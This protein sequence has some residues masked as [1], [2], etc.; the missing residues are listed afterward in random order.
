MPRNTG[1]SMGKRNASAGK[2]TPSSKKKAAAKRK[3]PHSDDEDESFA[4]HN[5]IRIQQELDAVKQENEALKSGETTAP[6]KHNVRYG[7]ESNHIPTDFENEV[8]KY[9]EEE[10]WANTKF[11]AN[12]EENMGVCATI[13]EGMPEFAGLLTGNDAKNKPTIK[14]FMDTYGKIVTKTLNS[15]RTNCQGNLRK[16]YL[17]R[18]MAG[19]Y[20]PT[21]KELLEAVM[22]PVS[23]MDDLKALPKLLKFPAEPDVRLED[24]DTLMVAW[25]AEKEEVEAKNVNIRADIE[26]IKKENA[27]IEIQRD[28]FQWYWME[29]LPCIVGKHNWGNNIR[30]YSLI[31]NGHFPDNDKK[32]Y[33]TTSD[34]ALLIVLMENCSQRF[35]YAYECK[36]NGESEDKSCD[37]YQSAWS[38]DNA[39]QKQY[40]GFHPD[41]RERYRKIHK[42]LSKLKRMPHVDALE[43][44]ILAQITNGGPETNVKGAPESGNKVRPKIVTV[45]LLDSDAEDVD[46]EDDSDIE[47]FTPTFQKPKAKK[48]KKS[49]K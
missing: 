22:R 33:I 14:K 27:P 21:A 10:V 49:K 17:K 5:L 29:L 18:A 4:D 39:G 41:G 42:K 32:K 13:M 34:E 24:Y 43:K 2:P 6:T 35:P 45:A 9:V 46:G 19:K 11:V 7:A 48:A 40:G 23:M 1:N 37:R 20:M 3:A 28:I 12:D 44:M 15:K 30:K 38:D 16:A 25:Q 36:K 8:K 47:D 26:R 31:H